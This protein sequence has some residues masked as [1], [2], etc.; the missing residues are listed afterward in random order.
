VR[1]EYHKRSDSSE[2]ETTEEFTFFAIKPD[3]YMPELNNTN[4]KL[5]NNTLSDLQI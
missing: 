5:E 4:G 2:P 1:N 3:E